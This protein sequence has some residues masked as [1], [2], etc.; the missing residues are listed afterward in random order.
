VAPPLQQ[1]SPKKKLKTPTRWI[2]CSSTQELTNAVEFSLKETNVVAE[3]GAQLR[4][5][6]RAICQCSQEAVLVDVAR[7]FPNQS[8]QRSRAMRR[9]GDELQLPSHAT[10]TEIPALEDW[11]RALFESSRSYDVF[12][13]DVNAI[14][15]NDLEMTSL[16][17]IREF[18]ALNEMMTGD[19]ETSCCRLVLIKSG[20]LNRL[21]NQLVH[22]KRWNAQ[23]ITRIALP[24]IICCVGVQEYRQTMN[25]TVRPGDAV[26]EVGC[27][28]GTTTALLHAKA[29]QDGGYGIG[30]DVGASIV[31]KAKTRHSHVFFAV[32]DAWKTADLLRIQQDYLVATSTGDVTNRRIGFDVVYVDVG[33]LSGSDG[34]LEAL[35]LLSSLSNAL[36]PRYIV[37]KSL[38]MQRLASTLVPYWQAQKV[39]DQPD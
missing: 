18:V 23:S 30:V 7:K 25:Q 19:D 37:I 22:F 29:T 24:Q 21:A 20:S 2:T 14:C 10:F 26:L 8:E 28:L 11:R 5:V 31:E 13:L 16:A 35:M 3:L 38:C 36:E 12:V 39:H 34:L 27:H 9:P 17:I 32:A 1:L 4:D 33:G 6:S 15:G